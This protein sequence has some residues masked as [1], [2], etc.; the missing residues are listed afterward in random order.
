MKGH[1]RIY[2]LAV[3][4]PLVAMLLGGCFG[5]DS[6]Y[7]QPLYEMRGII[8]CRIKIESGGIDSTRGCSKYAQFHMDLYPEFS[9][10]TNKRSMCAAI[11]GFEEYVRTNYPM[12]LHLAAEARRMSA[13]CALE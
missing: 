3:S 5:D 7:D 9:R 4:T 11:Q 6:F 13:K 12:N 8:S 10:E 1:L 2:R